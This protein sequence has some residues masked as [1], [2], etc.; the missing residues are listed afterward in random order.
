[1]NTCTG[2]CAHEYVHRITEGQIVWLELD[3]VDAARMNKDL[4][5]GRGLCVQ[6]QA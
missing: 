1:M 5:I 3:A 4:K 6:S 2:L